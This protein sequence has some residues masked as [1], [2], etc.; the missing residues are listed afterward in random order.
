MNSLFRMVGAG[1]E[2]GGVKDIDED[3]GGGNE[4]LRTCNGPY[5]FIAM[6][7][8]TPCNVLHG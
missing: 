1:E 7:H 8:W 3:G 2:G 5:F 4:N 6:K